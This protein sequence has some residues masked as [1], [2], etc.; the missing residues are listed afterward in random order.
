MRISD[1][2][3]PSTPLAI[4]FAGDAV[5][6]IEYRNS[7]VTLAQMEKMLAD[8][9][10]AVESTNEQ[11]ANK[12]TSDKDQIAQ[13]RQR[14][15][16]AKKNL[17]GQ[18]TDMVTLWDLTEDDGE[19]VI[20]LTEDRLKDVPTNVFTAIIKAVRRDQQADGEGK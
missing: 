7:S 13:M 4:P 1:A 9:E 2:I 6:N 10:E 8:A 20:P 15:E 5:L 14:V 3:S 18:I 19:T 11:E 12:G 17:I 16:K